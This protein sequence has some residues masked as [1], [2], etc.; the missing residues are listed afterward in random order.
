MMV[1][2]HS[3]MGPEHGLMD[4]EHDWMVWSGHDGFGVD[5]MIWEHNSMFTKRSLRGR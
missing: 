3:S 2:E 1:S 4:S 5:M